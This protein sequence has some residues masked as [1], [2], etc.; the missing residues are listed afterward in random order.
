MPLCAKIAFMR[1]FKGI[2]ADDKISVLEFGMEYPWEGIMRGI[3]KDVGEY[4]YY[5][6]EDLGGKTHYIPRDSVQR[7]SRIE[8]AKKRPIPPKNS[9]RKLAPVLK[10]VR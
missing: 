9:K 4:Y 2:F 7:I 10:I 5:I 3:V 8:K 1:F 6:I